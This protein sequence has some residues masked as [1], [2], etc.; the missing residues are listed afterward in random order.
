MQHGDT[1]FFPMK[2]YWMERL[3]GGRRVEV[4]AKSGHWTRLIPGRRYARFRSSRELPWSAVAVLGRCRGDRVTADT[5]GTGRAGAS[6]LPFD[7]KHSRGL[8]G[9]TRAAGARD[10]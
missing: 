9:Q 7:R 6:R 1:V 2:E 8:R 10:C 3:I 5:L 4:R